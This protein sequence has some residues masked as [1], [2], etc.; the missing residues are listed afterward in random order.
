[1]KEGRGTSLHANLA[2]EQMLKGTEEGEV[3]VAKENKKRAFD[4]QMMANKDPCS[5]RGGACTH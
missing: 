2:K 4:A 1:M 3:I 5:E